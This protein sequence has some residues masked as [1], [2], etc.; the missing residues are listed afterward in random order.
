MTVPTQTEPRFSIETRPAAL[1]QPEPVPAARLQEY[2][3]GRLPERN[4]R[5]AAELFRERLAESDPNSL[6]AA[7]IP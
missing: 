4:E 3:T 5:P 7:F 2:F 1:P 6:P